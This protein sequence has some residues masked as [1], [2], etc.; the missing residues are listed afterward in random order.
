MSD[1][2]LPPHRTRRI[3]LSKAQLRTELGAELLSLCESVTADGK[4]APEEAQGLRE[5]LDDADAADLPAA[6][7]L[8]EVVERALADGTVTTDEC[9][10][11]YRAV[12]AVLPPEV[13]RQARAVRRDVEATERDQVNA[14]RERERE[15]RRRDVQ[16]ASAN[17]MVAGVRHEGRGELIARYANAGDPVLFAER[18]RAAI[19]E[20][21]L[22]PREIHQRHRVAATA[23]AALAKAVGASIGERLGL[24]MAARAGLGVVSRETRVMKETATE[25]DAFLGER[26]VRHR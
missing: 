5:W 14:A 1:T 20:E 26:I 12:E 11:V 9:R 23:L 17:F 22:R 2:A 18:F 25:R 15:E 3:S 24:L 6:T 4:I 21:L 19:P 7:Y 8:R 10:E 16:I 13:R